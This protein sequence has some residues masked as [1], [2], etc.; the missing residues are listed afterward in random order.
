MTRPRTV[1]RSS[2]TFLMAVLLLTACALLSPV[3][4]Q[5]NYPPE[6]PGSTPLS[7]KTVGDVDLQLWLYQPVDHKADT[8]RRP[9]VVFFFGG[10]WKA[11]TPAQFEAHCQYLASR[12]IVAATADY[13][14]ATRH[15]CKADA[16]VEDA[17]SAVRWLRQNS[18]QLGIDPDRICAA[19]GSAGGHT[20]CCTAVIDGFEAANEDHNVSSKPNALALF[21][22][23]VQIA[24]LEGFEVDDVLVEKFPDIASRTGVPPEQLSP[25]HHVS[26]NLPPTIIFHGE[27]DDTVPF[28]TVQE[29]TRRVTSAGSRCELHGFAGAPHGFFN[30]TRGRTEQQKEQS[31]LWQRRTLR[32]LDEFLA[33]LNWL[34]QHRSDRVVDEDFATL[35]GELHNSFLRFT[36]QKTGHVAFLGGSITEMEGYRPRVTKWLQQRFPDTE[37][38]FTNAGISST[39]SNT[40]AF[41]LER[42]VLSQGPVDLLFVEFAV[43]DDQDA[44]HDEAACVRGMEGIIAHTRRHNPHADIVMTHFVNPGM[45]QTIAAGEDIL[46]ASQHERVARRYHVSSAYLSKEVAAR[47]ATGR[48]TW[49]EFG[50]THPGPAGN[51]LAADLVTSILEEG[52]RDLGSASLAATKHAMPEAPILET[53][54]SH[55]VLILP[56]TVDPQSGWQRSIPNWKEVAGSKRD[57]FLKRLMLHSNQ[58]AA[59]FDFTF[60]GTAIGAFVVAGPD[61]GRLDYRVD[62]GD[63]KTVELYHRY[64]KG[65]HYP[66]TVMFE[67][68]LSAGEH[69]LSLRVSDSAHPESRGTAARIIGFAVNQI[70][71]GENEPR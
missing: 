1:K 57:R 45:L 13:R 69:R 38:Q 7:Y 12:G 70:T 63:W 6:L 20:A 8:D 18:A 65:L 34:N 44:A 31:S 15:G 58:A 3:N 47:I 60:N 42:D 37:F 14:V 2:R 10:G 52:W 61:A 64:S 4:A 59:T 23:A 32:K 30:G 41:R 16:C 17:K 48:L 40:G 26:E 54:Y 67:S 9:A 21:N 56:E 22:P 36:T 28:T 35:R 39:C 49:K 27:A 46:S 51:Q 29:Y 19:G 25:I 68:A 55:G 33:S 24:P 62:D 43:N 5:Q 53:S 11:G 71:A 50:G 66:R